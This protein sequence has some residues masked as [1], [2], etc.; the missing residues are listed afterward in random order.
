MTQE[1]HPLFLD[2]LTI[3]I[4]PSGAGSVDPENKFVVSVFPHIPD[5]GTRW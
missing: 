4:A 2:H 1:Y 5:L 3:Y